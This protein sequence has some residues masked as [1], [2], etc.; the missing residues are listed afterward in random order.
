VPI[1]S[2]QQLLHYRLIEK[3]GE[4]G[5]GIVWKAVDTALD[6]EVAIKVLPEAFAAQAERLARFEREAKLLASLNHANIAAIY[7]LHEAEGQRFLAMELVPGEDLADRIARGPLPVDKA[8]RIGLQICEAL[9]TAHAHGVIHRDL[10]PANIRLTPEGEVKVLDFGLAKAFDV[11]AP[12]ADASLSP[13]ITSTGTIAGVIL[14]TAAYMSPEQAHGHAVDHRA[15]VWSFGCVMFEMLTGTRVFTG[16][17]IS[18]TLASVLKLEPDHDAVPREVPPRMRRLLRRCLT[19]APRQRLQSIG[20]ARIALEDGIAGTPDEF[21]RSAET[22]P[23]GRSRTLLWIAALAA[24]GVVALLAG[25]QLRG[26][27]EPP[28]RKLPVRFETGTELDYGLAPLAL[29]PDGRR[30]AFVTAGKLW[31]RDL[32]RLEAI[33][34]PGSEGS[35][36]PFWSPDGGFLGFAQQLK[37]F[38][39]PA[40]GGQP[41][42]ITTLKESI[43]GDATGMAWLTGDRI[44]L[45]S[46]WDELFEVSANGGDPR[47]IHAVD[48]EAESDF[49]H[50]SPLPDGRGVLYLIHTKTGRDTLAVLTGGTQKIV[51][52]AEG[53]E[54]HRPVYSGTGHILYERVGSSGGIWALPFSLAKLEVTGEPFLVAAGAGLP[55]VSRDG[56]LAYIRGNNPLTELAWFDS[57]GSVLGTFGELKSTWPFPAISPDGS[58]IAVSAEAIG[59]KSN[60]DVWVHDE[61]RG[62]ATRATFDEGEQG[63]MAWTA[64]GEQLIYVSGNATNNLELHIASADASGE[65]RML[66]DGDECRPTYD[67]ENP[68]VSPDGQTLAYSAA[69]TDA[70]DICILDLSAAEPKPTRFLH[71]AANEMA[72]RFHPSGRFLAYQSTE[73]GNDQIYIT[74]FPEGVGKWQVSTVG[75]TWPRWSG[76]GKKLYYRHQRA[77][78]AVDVQTDPAVRLSTPTELFSVELTGQGIG[79]GRPDGFSVSPDG[80]FLFVRRSKRGAEDAAAEGIVL[81]QNWFGEF[82]EGR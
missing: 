21:E 8:L 49:H 16:E 79:M 71:S 41:V 62:T 81:V 74:T 31:I 9:E 45:C 67:W 54:T 39:V 11:S 7:G 14:G 61:Q 64:D 75:G 63:S 76:D 60:W 59:E 27:P 56:T 68:H 10:K 22:G 13:T 15:D 46:G 44:V 5:M 37:L 33:E 29:S 52:R 2:G 25:R 73:S 53:H 69:G 24:T 82:R 70:N 12:S 26:T 17:S 6:R 23:A 35:S 50:V 55:S 65:P 1:E 47:A 36:D 57:G 66:W 77:L 78:M 19:K 80:R 58:R 40:T 28:L 18:D 51:F 38:K 34:I 4:G 20:E 3:I 30:I 32:E 43:G 48:P 42:M 72:P